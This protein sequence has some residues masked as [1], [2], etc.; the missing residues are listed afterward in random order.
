[1]IVSESPDGSIH[2]LEAPEEILVADRFLAEHGDCYSYGDG[3]LTVHATNGDV[4]YGLHH[5]DP[6]RQ[7]W[8]GPRG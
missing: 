1:M 7:V 5:Y 8:Q 2:I 6:V 3:I 4:S